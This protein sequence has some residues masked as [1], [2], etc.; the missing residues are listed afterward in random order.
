MSAHVAQCGS[1]V[2]HR[3]NELSI[4]VDR[5]MNTSLWVVESFTTKVSQQKEKRIQVHGNPGILS[6]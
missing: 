5:K 2:V 1:I 3:K 4:V 6:T